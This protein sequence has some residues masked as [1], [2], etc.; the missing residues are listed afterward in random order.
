MFC[1]D[2]SRNSFAVL[3]NE[4]YQSWSG[5]TASEYKDH[6]GLNRK[7]SL[8]DNMTPLELVTTIFSE[9]TSKELIEKTGAKGFVET[10]NAIHLA[11]NITKEALEKLNPH[12]LKQC[13]AKT[14][15]SL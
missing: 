2:F 11:G 8:R 10:K 12:S 3:T 15:F 1:A 9:T 5:Y 14:K 13:L 6:K 7:D 4:L